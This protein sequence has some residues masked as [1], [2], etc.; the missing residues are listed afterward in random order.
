MKYFTKSIGAYKATAT[1]YLHEPSKEIDPNRKY[2]VMVVVPGG[3]Y[4]WT[5]DRESEPVALTF[6]LRITMQSLL[7]TVRKD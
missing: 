1:F 5:S 4:F 3:A 6:L 2:P 7:I